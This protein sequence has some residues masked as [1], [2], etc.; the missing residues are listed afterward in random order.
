VTVIDLDSD[1]DGISDN[2]EVAFGTDPYNNDTDGDN[3][4]D[5]VEL[6]NTTSGCP[7]CFC[8]GGQD[9]DGDNII[10][11]LEHNS[12]DND[13]DGVPDV[14]D[15]N[16]TDPNSDSDGDGYTDIEEHLKGSDPLNPG[17]VPVVDARDDTNGSVP[18]GGSDVVALDIDVNDT[19]GNTTVTLGGDVNITEV[20]TT[21]TPLVIDTATGEV[22]VPANTVAGTYTGTYTICGIKGGV[23]DTSNCDTATVSVTVVSSV[24]DY[25]P[26]IFAKG[27][28]VNGSEGNVSLVVRIAEYLNGTN[29]QADLVFAIDKNT[30][31][32]VTFDVNETTRDTRTINNSDW[33]FSETP[34]FYKFTY[35]SNSRIFP[36]ASFSNIG[37]SG[38]FTS[39]ADTVGQFLVEVTIF[40]GTSETNLV[41]NKDNEKLEYSNIQ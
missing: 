27:T 12:D 17:V 39:P 38:V 15:T 5:D 14:N 20:N 26:T 6:G 18:S 21:G 24:P 37:I 41:N 13:S 7:P 30:N 8:G 33:E 2:D 3:I 32:Q 19:F 10:D 28:V 40:Q 9:S 22:T 16:N 36:G 1:G 23:I 29:S 31:V 25:K 35:K 4:T 34:V 11:A